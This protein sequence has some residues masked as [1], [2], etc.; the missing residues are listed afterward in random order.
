MWEKS[1]ENTDTELFTWF[2]YKIESGNYYLTYNNNKLDIAFDNLD[3]LKECVKLITIKMVEYESFIKRAN[4]FW[5]PTRHKIKLDTSKNL[6]WPGYFLEIFIDD[7]FLPWSANFGK[8]WDK[9]FICSEEMR[10]II[11]T[12]NR[13]E[14][15]RPNK[16]ALVDFLNIILKTEK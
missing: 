1:K 15:T 5:T 14:A 12:W 16:E 11:F 4:L 3:K 8:I 9:L 6:W 2:E 7:S 10:D 13:V